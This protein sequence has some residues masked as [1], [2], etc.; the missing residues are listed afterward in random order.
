MKMV[1]DQ[2]D[3]KFTPKSNLSLI[4]WKLG[5]LEFQSGMLHKNDDDVI[6]TK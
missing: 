5:K 1:L 4:R 3:L 2:N 6:E